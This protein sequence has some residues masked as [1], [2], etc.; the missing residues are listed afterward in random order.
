MARKRNKLTPNQT[1]Y[2]KELDRIKR[3]VRRAEKKGYTVDTSFIPET[4]KRVSK[5]AIQRLKNFKGGQVYEHATKLD[6]ATG[7]LVKGVDI[8]KKER[9]EAA[10]RGWETRRRKKRGLTSPKPVPDF[11]KFSDIII[12]NYHDNIKDFQDPVKSILDRWEEKIINSEGREAFA[13]ML[14]KGAEQGVFIGYYLSSDQE[15][16]IRVISKLLDFLPNLGNLTK[17]TITDLLEYD[18][19]WEFYE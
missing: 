19:D 8:R 13:E 14:Q 17:D 10:K 9:S 5:Q 16:A 18:E 2:K 12:Q 6:K 15:T 3:A 7:E 1:A 11:P 4:P